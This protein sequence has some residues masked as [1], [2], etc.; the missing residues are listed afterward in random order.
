MKSIRLLPA[1]AVSLFACAF[2]EPIDLLKG[3]LGANWRGF[4]SEEVP[5]GWSLE[6]GVLTFAPPTKEQK[7]NAQGKKVGGDL[8]TRE[9]FGDFELEMEW[10][11]AKG[12]NS[13]IFVRANEEF[14]VIWHSSLEIQIIDQENFK[15]GGKNPQPLKESQKSGALYDLYDANPESLK[16]HTEWNHVKIRMVGR[17]ITVT[18]NGKLVCDVDMDG[19]DF[20]QRFADSK[21]QK[22]S[23]KAGSFANGFIGLQDHGGACSYR[24]IKVTKL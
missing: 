9:T 8:V 22:V 3:E 4:K 23:P 18:Q 12:A 24:N 11:I 5:V 14:K 7:A 1:I 2:A 16:P 21:F 10:K 17:K 20:K 6:D 15:A 19:E 13:G